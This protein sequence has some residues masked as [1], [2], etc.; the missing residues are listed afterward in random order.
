MPR[1]QIEGEH[2]LLCS[3]IYTDIIAIGDDEVGWR[4]YNEREFH[5]K[6]WIA[7]EIQGY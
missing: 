1:I 6:I 7:I 5:T 4:V 2:Y 3:K